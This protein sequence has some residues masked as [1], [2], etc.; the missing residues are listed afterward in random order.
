MTFILILFYQLASS[1]AI[2][3]MAPVSG[4]NQLPYQLIVFSR[5]IQKKTQRHETSAQN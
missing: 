1:A 4:K 3:S 2:M 5:K